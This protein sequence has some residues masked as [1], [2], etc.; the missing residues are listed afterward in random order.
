MATS[1]FVTVLV[2]FLCLAHVNAE[3]ED[4]EVCEVSGKGSLKTYALPKN[5]NVKMPCKY[6]F[7]WIKCGK[8]TVKI[9]PGQ[10]FDFN[11]RYF[12]NTVWVVV[13]REGTN[14]QK[15]V[16]KGRTETKR[17]VMYLEGNKDITAFNVKGEASGFNMKEIADQAEQSV[18]LKSTSSSWSIKF[19]VNYD[20]KSKQSLAKSG[21]SFFCPNS[22]FVEESQYPWSICGNNT[23]EKA[24]KK[25]KRKIGGRNLNNQVIYD[26]LM[27]DEVTQTNQFC[28][29][30]VD[31]LKKC[32]DQ[33]ARINAVNKCAGIVRN[34]RI[35]KCLAN[36]HYQP[37][38][39]FSNCVK[40]NCL[41]D[42]QACQDLIVEM[43]G[44]P[45]VNGVPESCE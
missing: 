16:W 5:L 21:I 24:V 45:S 29:D 15:D 36:Y 28:A 14:G 9:F 23:D 38:Q 1:L 11:S 7:S 2:V 34:G 26:I 41:N 43:H 6:Q 42:K 8:D 18:T 17:V 44:C 30:T 33:D 22:E 40:Y 27:N 39:T 12:T 13:E 37:M 32:A 19:T 31:E 4:G 20:Q 25:Q 35:I 10:D 3:E